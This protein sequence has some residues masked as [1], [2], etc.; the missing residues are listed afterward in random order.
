[1]FFFCAFVIYHLYHVEAGSLCAHLLETFYHKLAVDFVKSFFCIYWN[2]HI[3]FILGFDNTVYHT[4][5]FADIEKS[6]HLWDKSWRC[7][8]ILRY[9]WIQF[10]SVFLHLC[11]SVILAGDILFYG[12]FIWFW[13]QVDGS[14]LEWVWKCSFCNFLEEFQ[15]DGVNYSLNVHRFH[16]WICLVQDSCVSVVFKSQIEFQ[17]L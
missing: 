10:A 13:Y 12:I 3:I 5:W 8:I 14:L 16:L 1:M 6:L 11:S 9:C 7:M 2:D 15:N 4:Y 17:Y